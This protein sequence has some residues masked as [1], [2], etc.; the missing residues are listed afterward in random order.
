MFC[1]DLRRINRDTDKFEQVT[2]PIRVGERGQLNDGV[3][4]FW[5]ED[6]AY[7]LQP[8]FHST[9]AEADVTITA[10][11]IKFY[12]QGFS[13]IEQSIASPPQTITLLVDPRAKVHATCG[14]L[15]AKTI[16]IPFDQYRDAIEQL[17][18]TFLSTPL[19]TEQGKINLPL[20]D[21]GGYRWSW[22]QKERFHWH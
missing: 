13:T 3:I 19:F 21:E 22:L 4:G 1:R 15:P 5:K 16:D 8:E 6:Q 12:E 18:I 17:K 10:S 2:V 20:P 9:V 7:A 14:V 11:N